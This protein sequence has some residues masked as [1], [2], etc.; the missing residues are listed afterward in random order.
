MAMCCSYVEPMP[1]TPRRRLQAETKSFTGSRRDSSR[2]GTW[3]QAF[4]LHFQGWKFSKCGLLSQTQRSGELGLRKLYEPSKS[5]KVSRFHPWWYG[6]AVC[7][8]LCWSG[9]AP[10]FGQ[11]SLFTVPNFGETTVDPLSAGVQPN[12]G[13][14]GE[15]QSLTGRYPP[16]PGRPST[17]ATQAAAAPSAMNRVAGNPPTAG[18]PAA[19]FDPF[20][21]SP[22]SLPRVGMFQSAD[23]SAPVPDPFFQGGAGAAPA[24]PDYPSVPPGDWDPYSDPVVVDGSEFFVIPQGWQDFRFVYTYLPR[25]GSGSEFGLQSFDFSGEIAFNP[26]QTQ[27][28]LLIRPGLTINLLDGPANTPLSNDV[29]DV[30][31]GLQWQP[32]IGP[33]LA[34]DLEF[35]P[36]LATDFNDIT[37]D[38]FRYP[39]RAAGIF[40]VNPQLDV[41]LGV[42]FLDLVETDFL[43]IAGVRWQIGPDTTVELLFPRPR[44]RRRFGVLMN[45]DLAW[46]VAGEFAAAAWRYR[47]V[48]VTDTVEY[49]DLRVL[50]G[51]E[52]ATVQ[53]RTAFV[54]FGYA[55]SREL[56]FANQPDQ[57][58]EDTLLLRGGFSF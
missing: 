32:R 31:V 12:V 57:R 4:R 55:F 49:Q 34:F 33:R 37:G 19:A 11:K 10:A 52:L 25:F 15:F 16:T 51:L 6:Y 44:Y 27:A 20:S 13:R 45:R 43:P 23:P 58:P 46:Y 3:A 17:T 41:V 28:P 40:S 36:T 42:A 48:G 53:G 9:A 22:L 39:A 21:T 38:S 24:L 54:E 47:D 26:L 29:Y 7:C 8:V 18:S 35:R 50:V 14:P 56:I 2:A 1:N 30:Y 5:S